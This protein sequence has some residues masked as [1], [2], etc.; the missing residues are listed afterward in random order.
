MDF[1]AFDKTEMEKYSDEVKCEWEATAFNLVR[2]KTK[3]RLPVK[4]S[5][6]YRLMEFFVAMGRLKHPF[7]LILNDTNLHVRRVPLFCLRLVLG[8]CPVCGNNH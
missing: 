1:S 8:Q 3:I 4:S 7:Y 2:A 6:I 5:L